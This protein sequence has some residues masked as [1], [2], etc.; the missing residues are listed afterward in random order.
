MPGENNILDRLLGNEVKEA[1]NNAIDRL[2]TFS[3]SQSTIN[4]L[5][6]WLL[7]IFVVSAAVQAIVQVSLS[8]AIS[9]SGKQKRT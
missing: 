3:L 1:G 2:T 7:V 4:A 8:N 6:L 9:K 5:G